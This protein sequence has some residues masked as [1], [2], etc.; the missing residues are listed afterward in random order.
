MVVLL[1]TAL[2]LSLLLNIALAV[3]LRRFI[4]RCLQFDR[5]FQLMESDLQVNIDYLTEKLGMD[6]L[7]DLPEVRALDRNF[8]AMRVRMMQMAEVIS[9]GRSPQQE[10]FPP[11]ET[12]ED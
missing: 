10:E 3:F 2:V 12:R 1:V 11:L 6:L 9:T 5:V 4:V 7:S 8:R